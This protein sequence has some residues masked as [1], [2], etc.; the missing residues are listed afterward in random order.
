ML[1]FHVPR[2]HPLL[3]YVEILKERNNGGYVINDFMVE[4]E[5][6]LRQPSLLHSKL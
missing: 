6:E 4:L 5:E 2:V 1:V 3:F